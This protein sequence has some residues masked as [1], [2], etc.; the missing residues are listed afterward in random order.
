MK[1]AE[2]VLKRWHLI[3]E[4][5][6]AE[7]ESGGLNLTS[8]IKVLATE[9]IHTC[10]RSKKIEF[11]FHGDAIT[12][13]LSKAVPIGLILNEILTNSLKYAYNDVTNGILE[14]SLSRQDGQIE[15]LARDYGCGL[16]PTELLEKSKTL[17]WKLINLLVRQ[18]DGKLDILTDQPG[19]NIRITF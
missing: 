5:L 2:G 19:A 14:L 10:G 1:K 15:L 4:N 3:H 17:G 12:V 13:E 9:I 11:I 18:I 7:H 6:F 8:Y 16:P